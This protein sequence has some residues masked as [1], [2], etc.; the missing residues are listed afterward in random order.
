MKVAVDALV[1][2]CFIIDRRGV[3]RYVNTVAAGHFP[4]VKPGDPL[5][6]GLR[7]P[8]LLE[9]LDRVTGGGPAERISWA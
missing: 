7:S 5:S 6:F 1:Q 3:T 4:S 9:A 2:P 8:A